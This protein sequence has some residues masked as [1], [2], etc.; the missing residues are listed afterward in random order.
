[1][2][3]SQL[4]SDYTVAH[5]YDQLLK[6]AALSPSVHPLLDHALLPPHLSPELLYP[7]VI[8]LVLRPQSSSTCWFIKGNHLPSRWSLT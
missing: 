2:H 4:C 7:L 6:M 3:Q 1:M 5:P 8:V